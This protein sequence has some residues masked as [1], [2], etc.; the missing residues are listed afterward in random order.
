MR[1][2]GCGMR[3]G[4]AGSRKGSWAA[5]ARAQQPSR[6]ERHQSAGR[7]H[8]APRHES[9]RLRRGSAWRSAA[10]LAAPLHQRQRF[11]ASGALAAAAA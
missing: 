5:S 2:Q 10:A 4:H 8:A 1:C 7:G 11:V 6:F 9:C 3:R